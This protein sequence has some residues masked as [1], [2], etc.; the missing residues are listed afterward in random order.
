MKP[1]FLHQQALQLQYNPRETQRPPNLGINRGSLAVVQ[2]EFVAWSEPTYLA[3]GPLFYSDKIR[4]LARQK[5]S[6]FPAI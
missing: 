2:L 3:L 5:I 6:M 4:K 1:S